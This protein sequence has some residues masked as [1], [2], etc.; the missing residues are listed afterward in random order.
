M[1]R[2]VLIGSGNVAYH[3]HRALFASPS[4][5]LVCVSAR[6][7]ASLDGFNEAVPRKMLDSTLPD[8]DIYIMAVADSAG[9]RG[10]LVVAEAVDVVQHQDGARPFRKGRDGRL[11]R[12]CRNRI[13]T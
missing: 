12:G 8:A 5:A 4:V 2:V 7:L 6:N 11:R 13:L 1:I 9:H 3:L 10:D